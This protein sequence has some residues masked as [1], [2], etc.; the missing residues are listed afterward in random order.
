MKNKLL[1]RALSAL[2]VTMAF[3][4]CRVALETDLQ[5]A[6]ESTTR[7]SVGSQMVLAATLEA[8]EG[9][10]KTSLNSSQVLWTA[11]DQIEVFYA[12]GYHATYTLQAS[13][14]GKAEGLF[15]CSSE[16]PLLQDGTCYAVYP[17]SAAVSISGSNISI[18]IPQAQTLTAGTFGNG[19]NIA[20]AK[21]EH[22]GDVLHFKNVLGAV[23]IQLSSS[24]TATRVRIQTKGAEYLC[25]S[26]TV[27]M[28]GD[29]PSLSIATGTTDN[30][31]VEATGSATGTAFYLMLPPDALASGF[32]TQVAVGN[33][34]MLKEA[35][36]SASNKITRSGIVAMPDFA[37]ESQVPSSFLNISAIPFGYWGAISSDP[38]FAF[39]KATSQYATKVGTSNRTFRMQDF[40]TQ[41]MYSIFLPKAPA[42]GLGVDDSFTV[43]LESVVGSTYTAPAD[44]GTF[45]LVQKTSNAG[46]FVSSDNTK[47]F[48]IPLED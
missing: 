35:P 17:A 7:R 5:N 21:A 36:V 24:I 2:S 20:V 46:W 8:P 27:N 41:K 1:I 4:A 33:N 12:G 37:F 39:N 6:Y 31:I 19:A 11:G 29:V 40:S 9:E 26:G 47:G 16:P 30:Q 44:A 43:T 42:L 14:A 34:A 15:E 23:C 38:T 28:S 18:N 3:T 25:G 10:T 13:S 22:I 32:I 45:R 48:I